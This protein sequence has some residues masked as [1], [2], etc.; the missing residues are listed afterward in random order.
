[1]C[2]F[3]APSFAVEFQ[4]TLNYT[5]NNGIKQRARV[6]ITGGTGTPNPIFGYQESAEKW[7]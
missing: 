2:R 4:S 1:M 7:V 6:C 3:A 5:Q